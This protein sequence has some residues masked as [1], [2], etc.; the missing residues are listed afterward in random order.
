MSFCALH[1]TI[2]PCHS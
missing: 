1:C 2:M